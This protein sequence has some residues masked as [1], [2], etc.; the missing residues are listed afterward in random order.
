MR[1]LDQMHE[2]HNVPI[3]MLTLNQW[4]SLVITEDSDWIVCEGSNVRIEFVLQHSA[5]NF[6][7]QEMVQALIKE[8]PIMTRSTTVQVSPVLT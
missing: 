5:L 1:K 6:K 2:T 4:K 3:Y 7:S 8:H